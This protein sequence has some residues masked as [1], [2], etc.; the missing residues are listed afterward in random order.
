MSGGDFVMGV[1]K[2]LETN[3]TV[4]FRCSGGR[5]SGDWAADRSRGC[6]TL[7]KDDFASSATHEEKRCVDWKSATG[8]V[9]AEEKA[10]LPSEGELELG[11]TL[12]K[13][14][15][16]QDGQ[17]LICEASTSYPP[18]Q[19]AER[20]YTE[21]SVN[22]LTV[23]SRSLSI[24]VFGQQLLINKISVSIHRAW[25]NLTSQAI[26]EGV[27]NHIVIVLSADIISKVVVI[28]LD[29]V[30]PS[31]SRHPIKGKSVDRQKTFFSLADRSVLAG[32]F[33]IKAVDLSYIRFAPD[34]DIEVN[35]YP[36]QIK[37]DDGPIHT[38]L[39][40]AENIMVTVHGKPKADLVCDHMDLSGARELEALPDEKPGVN[41]YL[42]RLQGVTEEDLGE[43]FCSATNKFGT[44][45]ESFF[46]TL[47]PSKPEVISPTVSSHADYYL[48]G[49]RAKSKSPLRN[50]TFRIQTFDN[51]MDV[52]AKAKR[53]ETRTVSLNDPMVAKVNT[54]SE[55]LQEFW[56]HLANLT[57][58]AKHAVHIRACNK[59]A[60]NEF[61]LQIPDVTFRTMKEYSSNKIDPNI[62]A[63]PPSAALRELYSA[64]SH[65]SACI[66]APRMMKL[67]V[68]SRGR[69]QPVQLHS[70]SYSVE[71]SLTVAISKSLLPGIRQS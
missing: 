36:P 35:E 2:S 32:L 55:E 12:E 13:V 6:P 1:K 69:N 5:H 65:R 63:Q 60:C 53:E 39:G 18:D 15:T 49:W 24:V 10:A 46:L 11:L 52:K 26:P 31:P 4:P 43:H 67:V 37:F 8:D 62:L 17:R 7:D 14:T 70:V 19:V 50:V 38:A 25:V 47:A 45:K 28:I 33:P 40:A 34:K 48:L 68:A 9:Y 56:H 23:Y 57:F 54:S 22:Y 21:I 20:Q 42:L 44:A 71:A 27:A 30:L 66:S 3:A 16:E 41:R 51:E 58:D 59:H 29:E 64:D 61:D